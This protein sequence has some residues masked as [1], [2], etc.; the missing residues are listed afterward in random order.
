M[1]RGPPTS[2]LLGRRSTQRPPFTVT[3][4]ERVGEQ[5]PWLIGSGCQPV[6]GAACL[7][8]SRT[9]THGQDEVTGVSR[10]LR[11]ELFEPD[12][13]G[14]TVDGLA[15]DLRLELLDLDVDSVS[16]VTR[17]PA[18][19]GSKGLEMAAIGA[20]LVSVKDSLPVLNAVVT[21]A[22][23]WL[24]RA[25]SSRRSLKITVDGRTLE[26][27]AATAEQ[28]QQVV[29]EFVRSLSPPGQPDTT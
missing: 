2:S 17:R 23:Q 11:I 24:A 10:E 9:T 15:S 16:P 4:W 8:S 1:I 25:S 28:Q 26:L 21:A 14:E 18:P 3:V 6:D 20:L 27:S 12:A 22:R 5:V 19:E 13:D 29:A 7:W